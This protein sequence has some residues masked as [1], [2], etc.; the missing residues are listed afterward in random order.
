MGEYFDTPV[1]EHLDM[2]THPESA[3]SVRV[4]PPPM[5]R[6]RQRVIVVE[7]NERPSRE[8]ERIDIERRSPRGVLYESVSENESD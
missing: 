5:E 4:V 7:G 6:G 1:V 8:G 2:R 3:G